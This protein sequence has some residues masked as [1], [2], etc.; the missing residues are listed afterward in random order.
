MKHFRKNLTFFFK[1]NW[2]LKLISLLLSIVI[3]FL[4]C[5]YVDPD[6]DVTVPNIPISVEFEG[7][8]PEAEGLVMMTEV[9]KTVS[10]RVRGSRDAI[11]MMDESA[12]TASIDLK[13]VT[14]IGEYDLDVKVSLENS[15]LEIVSQSVKTIKVKFDKKVTVPVTLRTEKLKI[16]SVPD[17]YTL[18]E[19]LGNQNIEVTGPKELVETVKEAVVTVNH[20]FKD[21]SEQ[22]YEFDLV[23]FDG[24]VI[25]SKLLTTDIEK[26]HIRYQVL[27]M[28]EDVPFEV[29][30]VNSI[31]GDVTSLCTVECSP[32]DFT[33]IGG[34][35]ALESYN[36]H[37]L[38]TI[39]LS[40][41]TEKEYVVTFPVKLPN[42]NIEN[43]ENVTEVT[44]TVKFNETVTSTKLNVKKIE[45]VNVPDGTTITIPDKVKRNGLDIKVRG[46]PEA[47]A[48]LK[49]ED[50]KIVVDAGNK[51][52]VNGRNEMSIRVEFPKDSGVC[53]IGPYLLY[54]DVK[55]NK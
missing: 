23:D 22:D 35:D 7:S 37:V 6:T 19:K 29:N 55:I 51:S 39:D 40:E 42:E 38:G 45:V 49:T 27:R 13:N 26:V 24:N 8:L 33:L 30:I 2:Q 48:E 25:E 16:D 43:P 1:N 4:I 11:A 9:D 10:V 17:G 12:I 47:I 53:A 28:K 5:E 44:V 34:N 41:V 15:S 54:V 3:W 36:T 31:G 52:F 21:T 20:E 32:A 46:L 14:H 18:K 50:V